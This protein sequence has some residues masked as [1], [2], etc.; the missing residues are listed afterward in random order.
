M[1]KRLREK[2]LKDVFFVKGAQTLAQCP[3]G[4]LPELA[5]LGR[6]NVGKSS[7]LNALWGRRRLAYV[8][9][10]P[11]KTTEINFFSV[12]KKCFYVDMPGYGYARVAKTLKESWG[13][14]LEAYIGKRANLEHVFVLVDSRHGLKE[15]DQ[16]TCLWLAHLGRPFSVVFT[17]SDKTNPEGREV[18]VSALQAIWSDPVCGQDYFFVS[19]KRPETLASLLDFIDSLLEEKN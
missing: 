15:S 18:C 8:S 12:D 1:E 6:S 11:G 2:V 19:I 9:K 4:L 7:L 16:T 10:K 5:F 17:K 13:R 3:S 14:N